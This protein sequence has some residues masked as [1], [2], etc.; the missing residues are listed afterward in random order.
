[1]AITRA[2]TR[3]LVDWLDGRTFIGPAGFGDLKASG[4]YIDSDAEW[5]SEDTGGTYRALTGARGFLRLR[6]REGLF[7]PANEDSP[8]W[9]RVAGFGRNRA[10]FRHRYRIV[11]DDILVAGAPLLVWQGWIYPPDDAQTAGAGEVAFPLKSYSREELRREMTTAQARSIRETMLSREA[12]KIGG[13]PRVIV[14][15]DGALPPY[16]FTQAGEGVSTLDRREFLRNL[17]YG[18]ATDS[19]EDEQGRVVFDAV[20]QPR[21]PIDVSALEVDEIEIDSVTRNPIT[22]VE[23]VIRDT[24]TASR[25]TKVGDEERIGSDTAGSPLAN[26]ARWGNRADMSYF[27]Q[28]LDA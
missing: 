23:V 4:L 25:W 2:R 27:G 20:S 18:A 1:M 5:G 16:D 6:D 14:R 8:F 21:T 22:D 7:D 11:R 13:S 19:Y 10:E 24:I 9:Y 28:T 3:H 26:R 12:Q 17:S 15:T